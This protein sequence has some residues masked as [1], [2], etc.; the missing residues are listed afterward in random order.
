MKRYMRLYTRVYNSA[1]RGTNDER[2]GEIAEIG[3]TVL[4]TGVK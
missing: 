2:L 3:G 4:V 1:P